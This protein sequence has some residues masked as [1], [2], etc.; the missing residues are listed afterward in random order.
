MK[1][2]GIEVG[3]PMAVLSKSLSETRSLGMY[4]C[5]KYEDGRSQLVLEDGGGELSVAIRLVITI[6]YPR[7]H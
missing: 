6:F 7:V 1:V 3:E 5:V 4:R 2:P